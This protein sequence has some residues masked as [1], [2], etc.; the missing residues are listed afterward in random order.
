MRG[1]DARVQLAKA[2]IMAATDEDEA[3]AMLGLAIELARKDGVEDAKD[4]VHQPPLQFKGQPVLL[5]AWEEGQ[6]GG[7]ELDGPV[8]AACLQMTVK[9]T[10]VRGIDARTV[11]DEA[12]AMAVTD[13][14]QAAALFDRALKLATNDG[15]EDGKNGIPN[16]PAE[17][18]GQPELLEAWLDG[19]EPS[20]DFPAYEIVFMATAVA[21]GTT[22]YRE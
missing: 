13:P 6:E 19:L 16:P 9:Q 18:T 11:M 17:F 12:A 14:E 15:V 2:V 22:D 8:E 20:L 4:R 5:A 10:C 1:L 21:M 7:A 3:D